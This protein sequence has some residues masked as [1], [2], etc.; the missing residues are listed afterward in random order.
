MAGKSKV[1]GKALVAGSGL[2]S[3]NTA[4]ILGLG[5]MPT[6]EGFGCWRQP[7]DQL[8]QS[9]R[10]TPEP[11]LW[12]LHSVAGLGQQGWLLGHL[13]S[14]GDRDHGQTGLRHEAVSRAASC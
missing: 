9:D 12:T 4:P 3:T 11:L 13:Y 1:V 14:G 10:Q 5:R 6:Q 8:L 2:V 7:E